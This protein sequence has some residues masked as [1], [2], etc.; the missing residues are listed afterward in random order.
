MLIT[1][2]A[3]DNSSNAASA[4]QLVTVKDTNLIPNTQP[5]ANANSAVTLTSQPVD[6]VLTGT[7]SDVLPCT[8]CA[9]PNKVDPLQFRISQLP[10]NGEFVAPLNPY[11]IDDYRTDKTGVLTDDVAFASATDQL[12]WL[13]SE[14]CANSQPVPVN[15]VFNPLY[16][17]VTDAGQSYYLDNYA[18]CD[19]NGNGSPP[20]EKR[21]RISHWDKDRTFFGHVDYNPSNGQHTGSF[22]F[23]PDGKIYYPIKFG[24]TDY[25]VQVCE[26]DDFSAGPTGG[27]CGNSY[28]LGN[29]DPF[30]ESRIKYVRV[31]STASPVTNPLIYATDGKH[32]AIYHGPAF[33]GL[34]LN[35]A[36]QN[37]F[38]G[39]PFTN[40]TPISGGGSDQAHGMELDSEGN[41]YIADT[42]RNRIHKFTASS[43]DAGNI[44]TAGSYVGWMGQCSTSVNQAC[45]EDVSDPSKG[46]SKGF[47]CTDA[48]CS[49]SGDGSGGVE[50]QFNNPVFLAMDPNDVL[51]VADYSNQRIQRFASDGTFAGQAKSAGNGVNAATEGSFVL[52]NMGP[53]KHVSVNSEQFFVVDQA[54]KFVHVFEASP[55]KEIT[56]SSATVSYVSNFD[57]H[58]QDDTF[59]FVVNDG[60]LNSASATVTVTVNR[61]H[62]AP[63][64]VAKNLGV[65]EDKPLN[66][67]LE[68]DDPDGIL[69][70]DAYG[71]DTL[72]FTITDLPTNGHLSCEPDVMGFVA[73]KACTYTPN[74]DFHG[75][76]RIVYTLTDDD[77]AGNLTSIPA[78]IE[79]TVNSVNDAPIVQIED[80]QTV[81]AG[82]PWLLSAEFDDDPGENY[83]AYLDW[84]DGTV[85]TTGEIILD[86][87]GTPSDPLDDSSAISGVVISGVET[88]PFGNNA[89]AQAQHTYTSLGPRS[90]DLCIRDD[91]R[92]EGCN[93]INIE[94]EHVVAL[95]LLTTLPTEP[96]DDGTAFIIQFDVVNE[97]PVGIAGIDATNVS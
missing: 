35:D 61:N 27:S 47:I 72:S 4:E 40:C 42:C 15:F 14:Y 25:S 79:I 32:I 11:F 21:L 16:V 91:E 76:D 20:I 68:G 1:W 26:A 93:R 82:F 10:S 95:S 83:S 87:N 74:I 33:K 23:D 65:D 66:I 9:Q 59:D 52:G 19:P 50:G 89:M 67:V 88:L 8:G 58:S 73:T 56:D 85:E 37:D 49:I 69:N 81:G 60:L 38:L 46:F 36:G 70:H 39:V 6:I 43:I 62:R 18:V 90:V 86:D 29:G 51:Y 71:L 2:T 41:F 96:I 31:D 80:I 22:V 34:L 24:V 7:D 84:N 12:A 55:F 57:F 64:A 53:P 63:E 28:S 97:P 78:V 75:S 54:E 17:H 48:T 13:N 92:G 30:D 5:V 94:V 77:P 3:T 44:L 45:V